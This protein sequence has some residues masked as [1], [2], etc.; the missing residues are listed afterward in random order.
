MN[1]NARKAFNALQKIGAPVFERNDY[2][3]HFILSGEDNSDEVWADYWEA[4]SLEK[5]LECGKIVWAFGINQKVHDILT[6]LGLYAEW[7]NPGMLGIY[8]I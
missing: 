1:R 6:P 8:T 3:A 2:R 4:A 5:Q 7:I